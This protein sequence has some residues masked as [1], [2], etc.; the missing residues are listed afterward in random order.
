MTVFA[1]S[2]EEKISGLQQKMSQLN[3]REEDLEEHFIR[4]SGNGGQHV[5]KTSSAV[6]LRH[7]P[8][9]RSVSASLVNVVSR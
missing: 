8:S 9:G 2:E 5:N 4:S 6:W 1:V 7:I 3:V